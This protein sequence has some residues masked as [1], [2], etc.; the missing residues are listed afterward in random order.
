M[1]KN[2]QRVNNPNLGAKQSLDMTQATDRRANRNKDHRD[3]QHNQTLEQRR[4]E[5][6]ISCTPPSVLTDLNVENTFFTNK[7]AGRR[8]TFTATALQNVYGAFVRPSQEEEIRFFEKWAE[9]LNKDAVGVDEETCRDVQRVRLTALVLTHVRL[10]YRNNNAVLASRVQQVLADWLE[11]NQMLVATLLL[12]PSKKDTQFFREFVIPLFE[13]DTQFKFCQTSSPDDL[14]DLMSDLYVQEK[15]LLSLTH[16]WCR[17]SHNSVAYVEKFV[18]L[19]SKLKGLYGDADLARFAIFDLVLGLGK[20]EKDRFVVNNAN[21][22][23][24][25]RFDLYQHLKEVLQFTQEETAVLVTGSLDLG[26]RSC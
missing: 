5:G 4:N 20:D 11:Q 3:V 14:A 8:V 9:T 22:H 23:Y 19:P 6:S 12:G 2:K 17:Y 21:E 15:P 1:S 10:E 7:T 13:Q 26:R 24:H 18:D 16:E 25:Y